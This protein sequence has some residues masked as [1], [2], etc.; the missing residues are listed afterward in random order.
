[1]KS[2]TTARKRIS[3]LVER[4]SLVMKCGKIWKKIVL[5][6]F[7]ILYMFLLCAVKVTIFELKLL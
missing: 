6:S 2:F 3:K 7:Q 1:M 4:Q 5:R